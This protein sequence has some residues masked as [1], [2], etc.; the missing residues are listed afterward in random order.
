MILI[1]SKKNKKQKLCKVCDL[2]Y[3]TGSSELSCYNENYE[4]TGHGSPDDIVDFDTSEYT[5]NY[6]D[7]NDLIKINTIILK[8][9]QI[10]A[11][12]TSFHE[13]TAQIHDDLFATVSIEIEGYPAVLTEHLGL[14]EHQILTDDEL[15]F[16]KK[17]LQK[18]LEK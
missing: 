11:D 18:R 6:A 12:P 16:L 2:F 8:L 5:F 10:S 14:L 3:Y 9:M 4:P 17:L 15:S 1:R 13:F 7:D